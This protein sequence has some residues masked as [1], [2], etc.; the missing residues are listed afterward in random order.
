MN[1][2]DRQ[3]THSGALTTEA[4]GGYGCAEVGCLAYPLQ[5]LSENERGVLLTCEHAGIGVAHVSL[6]GQWLRF[7]RK[8]CQITGYSREVLRR[9]T[10][11]QIT[12]P[13]DQEADRGKMNRLLQGR[14]TSYTTEKRFVRADGALLWLHL[15]VSLARD[16]SGKPDHFVFVIEDISSQKET[17]A[18]RATL[19]AIV[20][21]SADAIISQALDGSITSWNA[22]AERMFGYR[23]EEVLGKQLLMLAPPEE[24]EDARRI[25]HRVRNGESVERVEA[26]RLRKDGKRMCVALSVSPLRDPAGRIIGIAK[27]VRDITSLKEAEEALR[28][29]RQELADANTRLEVTVKERTA[30]LQETLTELEHMSYS[31]MHDMRAPLRAMTGYSEMIEADPGTVLS[32]SSREFLGRT[33]SAAARMDSLICGV[34]NYGLLVRQGLDLHRVDLIQLLRGIIDT[35]PSFQPPKAQIELAPNLPLVLGNEA[36]LTQCFANLFDNAVKF[37]RA[38]ELPRVKVTGEVAN[39]RARI[40]VEDNGV[41]IPA[42][43]QARL[44]NLFE[45]GGTMRDGTGIGLAIVRKAAE[46]MGGR[47]GVDSRPGQGSRFWLELPEVQSQT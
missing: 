12:F 6:E 20:Q 42:S 23:A 13:D 18:L 4:R 21:N 30:R 14:L 22:A 35:Y 34:L 8:L 10:V 43:L 38:G 36:A 29:I 45:R 37:V 15:T 24:T 9:K 32:S 1:R 19:A 26:V 46:R 3:T 11:H 17:D 44:F 2:Q 28:Q 39:G 7:N 27:I 31:I 25:F 5:P 40:A 16:S 33:K 47:V 41:G